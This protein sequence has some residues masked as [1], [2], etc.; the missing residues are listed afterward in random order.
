MGESL[1]GEVE[2]RNGFPR[3][4]R[5]NSMIV[6]GISSGENSKGSMPYIGI[7]KP[8]IDSGS[9]L[10]F[11]SLRSP[12]TI[13]AVDIIRLSERLCST[14]MKDKGTAH[15]SFEVVDSIERQKKTIMGVAGHS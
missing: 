7:I 12:I 14:I 5:T 9:V 11:F 10:T 1:D 3:E 13:S 8:R 6:E 4:K 15:Y 2:E